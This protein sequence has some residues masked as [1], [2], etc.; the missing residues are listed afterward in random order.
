ML[1][2]QHFQNVSYMFVKWSFYNKT[3][4]KPWQCYLSNILL[5]IWAY[6]G[7]FWGGGG[8]DPVYA[9][10][11]RE[12]YEETT[13]A[14][15]KRPSQTTIAKGLKR[16]SFRRLCKASGDWKT[17]ALPLTAAQLVP[18]T[19]AN[20]LIWHLKHTQT[21][22]Y[23]IYAPS[24]H[25]VLIGMLNLI[26]MY[27]PSQG[28]IYFILTYNPLKKMRTLNRLNQVTGFRFEKHKQKFV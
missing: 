11:Q 8:T 7:F 10:D 2:N 27:R 25:I 14:P 6:T 23:M 28:L 4:F 1:N 18:T 9:H 17:L 24:G 15:S 21:N 13:R 19:A 22:I 12:T 3:N 26:W 16:R 5:Q 20:C